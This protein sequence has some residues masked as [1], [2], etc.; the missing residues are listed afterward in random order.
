M[1]TFNIVGVPLADVYIAQ[2][3]TKINIKI[4]SG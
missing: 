3:V 1:T 2:T 4:D